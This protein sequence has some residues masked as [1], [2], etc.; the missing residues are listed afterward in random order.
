[1]T[2]KALAYAAKTFKVLALYKKKLKALK[3]YF[4]DMYV[5]F[6][7][8]RVHVHV[9]ATCVDMDLNVDMDVDMGMDMDINMNMDMHMDMDMHSIVLAFTEVRNST[10]LSVALS[11]ISLKRY[12]SANAFKRKKAL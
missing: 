1:V 9:H 10:E 12:E 3:R 2:P 11:N 4:M 6:S 5:S 8:F 7:F